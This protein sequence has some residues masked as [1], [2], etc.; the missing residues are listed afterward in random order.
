[1]MAQQITYRRATVEDMPA[2]AKMAEESYY[3]AGWD[4]IAPY[5]AKFTEYIVREFIGNVRAG[6]IVA[7]YQGELIGQIAV[8]T[9]PYTLNPDLT[10]ASVLT[11]F[12]KPDHHGGKISRALFS[13]AR[14]WSIDKADIFIAGVPKNKKASRVA[15]LYARKGMKPLETVFFERLK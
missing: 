4:E 1:M 8:S 3:A 2:I 15:E 7:E 14:E 12:V 13:A 10:I 11:W 9:G 5:N 6:V